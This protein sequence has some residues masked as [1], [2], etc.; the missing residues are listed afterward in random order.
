MPQQVRA[1]LCARQGDEGGCSVL[2]CAHR[3]VHTHTHMHTFASFL[4]GTCA[5]GCAHTH[6][7]VLKCKS[8]PAPT[9]R[10]ICMLVQESLASQAAAVRQAD[11]ATHEAAAREA[12]LDRLSARLAEETAK[13][14]ALRQDLAAITQ[15]HVRWWAGGQDSHKQLWKKRGWEGG[16]RCP[17]PCVHA[18]RGGM[19]ERP[20][21]GGWEGGE[22]HLCSGC[23]ALAAVHCTQ[24]SACIFGC[25]LPL[26][27]RA[28]PTDYVQ[29]Y[30]GRPGGARTWAGP[31]VCG[32]AGEG[33]PA[34]TCP[35]LHVSPWP[36]R[37]KSW[38]PRRACWAS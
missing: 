1:G 8:A 24:R 37:S 3:R 32:P 9:P 16:G 29:W 34:P 20:L 33:A 35:P 27:W 30:T 23:I 22:L 31:L 6:A 28:G 10:R 2:L 4:T 38:M 18:S 17:V 21:A 36:R 13:A 26:L 15:Q 19:K 5:C 14:S 25:G 11:S 7:T 12:S